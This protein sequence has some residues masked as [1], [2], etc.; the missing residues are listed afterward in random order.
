MLDYLHHLEQLGA[1]G[2]MQRREGH[3]ASKVFRI[4]IKG[5]DQGCVGL[6]RQLMKRA[7]DIKRSEILRF[8]AGEWDYVGAR[9]L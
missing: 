6:M 2:G 8:R 5:F 9:H 1:V 3:M 7:V 4:R